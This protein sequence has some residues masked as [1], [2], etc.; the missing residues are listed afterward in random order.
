VIQFDRARAATCLDAELDWSAADVPQR[1]RSTIGRQP[2][3]PRD[4]RAMDE[5]CAIKTLLTL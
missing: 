3:P 5:R 4:T 2:R 1:A